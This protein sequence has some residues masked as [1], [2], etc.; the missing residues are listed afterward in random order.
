MN[1]EEFEKLVRK[2]IVHYAIGAPEYQNVRNE[3]TTEA[4]KAQW[5]HFTSRLL[6][7]QEF[8]FESVAGTLQQK[9][10]YLAKK[11]GRPSRYPSFYAHEEEKR[12]KIEALSAD[13]TAK[14]IHFR[15]DVY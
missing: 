11:E 1:N 7:V 15:P 5:E 13:F 4:T 8:L 6:E 10:V 3:I 12:Q 9:E 14:Q 2:A